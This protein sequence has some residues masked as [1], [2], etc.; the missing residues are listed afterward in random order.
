MRLLAGVFAISLLV[1][2][3]C[4]AGQTVTHTGMT[5]VPPLPAPVKNILYARP[6]TLERPY[7]YD[8]SKD[9][10]TVSTGILV[11]LDVDTALVIPRDSLEPVLYASDVAVQRLNHG[12]KSGKVI[13]IV[14]GHV[15]LATTPIWFGSP[16]L[17]E[18]VTS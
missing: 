3:A 2:P 15:D 12:H 9:R 17:P 16:N 18:R 14:P 10:P 5:S 1:L 4:A 11:V 13:A 8:W 7:R 6:F